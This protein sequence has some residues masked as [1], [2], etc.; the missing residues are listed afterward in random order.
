MSWL[1]RLQ[2][3]TARLSV[4]FVIYYDRILIQS[5]AIYVL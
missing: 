5:T 4:A 2:A 3:I 1:Q